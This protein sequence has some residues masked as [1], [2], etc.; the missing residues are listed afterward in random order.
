MQKTSTQV[1]TRSFRLRPVAFGGQGQDAD[2]D[3]N[4]AKSISNAVAA[5]VTGD[6]V[7]G[8]YSEDG[9]GESDNI[10]VRF[11]SS[12]LY[13]VYDFPRRMSPLSHRASLRLVKAERLTIQT[14]SAG[15][16]PKYL[17]TTSICCG[18]GVL[19]IIML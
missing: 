9:E 8:E 2:A 5:P 1:S 6:D 19:I 17:V 18:I 13:L 11:S 16:G 12:I 4:T 14:M 7:D 15:A 3:N 10:E